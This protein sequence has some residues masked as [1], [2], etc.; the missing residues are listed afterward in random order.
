MLNERRATRHQRI[1]GL[2]LRAGPIVPLAAFCFAYLAVLN[3]A[4][5]AL[6]EEKSAYGVMHSSRVNRP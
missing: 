2:T 1:S 3:R 4:Q 5:Q 6:P